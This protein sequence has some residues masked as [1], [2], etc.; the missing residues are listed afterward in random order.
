MNN[1]AEN[2][3]FLLSWVYSKRAERKGSRGKVMSR[4]REGVLRQIE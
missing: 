4:L 1:E 2:V 3:F